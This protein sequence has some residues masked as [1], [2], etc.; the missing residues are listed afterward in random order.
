MW[1]SIRL[2]RHGKEFSTGRK[3]WPDCSFTR[4]RSIFSLFHT[5]LW[6]ARRINFRTVKVVSWTDHLNARICNWS[7]RPI[8]GNPDSWVLEAG[9]RLKESRIQVL[10]TNTGVQYLES[11]I[12][13]VESRIQN[14]PGFPYTRRSRKFVRCPVKA[15]YIVYDPMSE[16]WGEV[17][18]RSH[19]YHYSLN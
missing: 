18:S 15:E 5:E 4:D 14:Y 11:G 12:H 16:D 1:L 7:N 17:C 13:S 10:P 9:L 8:Q 6:T 3:I 2:R 19:S